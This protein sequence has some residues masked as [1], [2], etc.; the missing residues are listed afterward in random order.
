MSRT[1]VKKALGG[2]EHPVLLE[3]AA[4]LQAA[5]KSWSVAG[6]LGIDTEFVR[7]RTYRADLGLV[8]VSDGTTAWLWDPLRFE[9]AEAVTRLFENAGIVKVLH[10][11]SEDL[12]VLLHSTGSLPEPLMDTQ[13]ACAM[14]GQPLQLSYQAAARWL[15]E[16]EVEKDQ[17]RSNWLR[18][19]L[20]PDQ[21]RYAAIDVVLL[22]H[23]YTELRA[24]LERATRWAWLQ[25][26]VARTQRN[27]Q[28]T[29]DPRE[30]YLRIGGGGRLD[31]NALR[32][33]RTLAR[34]R[35]ETAQAR[36]RARGFVISDIGLLELAR[37]RPT[38]AAELR[39]VAHVHPKALERFAKELLQMIAT[40]AA[41]R[42]P[43]AWPAPL[44]NAQ[45]RQLDRMKDCVQARAKA[46]EVD[47]ALL[48]SRREL[49]NLLRA[50]AT[51]D[52]PPERF[53]GWR[54]AV[55]TD[56]LLGLIAR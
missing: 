14:L 3:T 4:Q 29:V 25:E 13:I 44:T 21:L 10:S 32:A 24:R 12:E 19:P 51:G 35:E 28:Q 55:V 39:D 16:V 11:G 36:N 37:L 18:R 56:E 43:L 50:T 47:P 31:E 20:Q 49:E 40:A 46:L 26:D 52:P 6:V 7:E 5:E 30:A 27:A 8:Q 38:T 48:A 1:T 42:S 33:L 9:S 34:W 23:M 41:D 22:P 15:F 53:L 2:A 17:T 45:R 54:K